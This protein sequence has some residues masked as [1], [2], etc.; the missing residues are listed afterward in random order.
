[1]AAERVPKPLTKRGG[2][3]VVE[4]F[5]TAIIMTLIH[6]KIGERYL[7]NECLN[8]TTCCWGH[9]CHFV[10]IVIIPPSKC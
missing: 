5:L 8:P 6:V 10:S 2:P 9:N 7:S 1:M 3:I 4:H